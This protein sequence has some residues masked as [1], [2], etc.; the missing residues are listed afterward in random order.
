[1]SEWWTYTLADT[2]M[3][4]PRT[5]WRLF[6]LHGQD[7]WP[8]AWVGAVLGMAL[9]LAAGPQGLRGRRARAAVWALLGLAWAFVGLG[10]HAQRYASVHTAAPWF[11]AGFGLQALLL[12]I[13][14]WHT[15]TAGDAA[16]APR[17]ARLTSAIL[18]A[19]MAAGQPALDLLLGRPQPQWLLLAPD[20]TALATLGLLLAWPPAPGLPAWRRRAPWLLPLLWSAVSG[21]TLWTLEQPDALLPPAAAIGAVL[22]AT[23]ARRRTAPPPSPR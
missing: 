1:M 19:W 5:Y 2:L 4:T 18:L 17:A 12:L 14:A 20:P 13:L 10:F 3:F 9:A 15:A 7:W 23:L 8:L 11:G 22:A 6:E 21:A 16:P